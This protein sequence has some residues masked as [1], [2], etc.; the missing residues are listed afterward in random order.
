RKLRVFLQQI[1]QS[2]VI[3]SN[4][5]LTAHHLHTEVDRDTLI[6]ADGPHMLAIL[7]H[8]VLNKLKTLDGFLIHLHFG[9]ERTVNLRHGIPP[10]SLPAGSADQFLTRIVA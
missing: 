5:E 4:A 8:A 3:G 2:L 1:I 6:A 7:Q 10:D 9:S